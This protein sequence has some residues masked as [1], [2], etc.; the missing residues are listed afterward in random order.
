MSI[1]PLEC[2][3]QSGHNTSQRPRSCCFLPVL[4]LGV[5]WV[6]SLWLWQSGHLTHSVPWWNGTHGLTFGNGDGT[7]QVTVLLQLIKSHFLQPG[8]LQLWQTLDGDGSQPHT[9]AWHAVPG[10]ITLQSK[11]NTSGVTQLIYVSQSSSFLL[12]SH[13]VKQ[14]ASVGSNIVSP[15]LESNP[16]C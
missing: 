6:C 12:V 13:K 7:A 10:E 15:S 9:A 3:F 11:E 2:V 1:V 5:R 8:S 16:L 4:M 14:T